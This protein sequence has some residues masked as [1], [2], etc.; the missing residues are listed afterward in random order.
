MDFRVIWTQSA[1]GDLHGLVRYISRDDRAVADRFGNLIVSKVDGL[2][3]FPRMGRIVP[4]FAMDALRQILVPPYRIIY[5]IN[6]PATTV[7]VL[8][9]WHGARDSLDVSDLGPGT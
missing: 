3:R 6:D 5:E 9:V 1:L 8:R 7:S 4:E 2:G